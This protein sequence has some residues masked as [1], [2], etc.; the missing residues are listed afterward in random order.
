MP[1]FLTAHIFELKAILNV[2]VIIFFKHSLSGARLIGAQRG[3]RNKFST[4]FISWG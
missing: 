4:G 2:L 1:T 3:A